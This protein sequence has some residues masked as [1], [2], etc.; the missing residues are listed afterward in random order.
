MQSLRNTLRLATEALDGVGVDCALIG[1]LAMAG[2]GVHRATMDVDLLIDGGQREVARSALQAAGF[3]LQAETPEVLHFTGAGALDLLLANR[4][5]TQDML[6][7][8]RVLEPVQVRCVGAEDI[9]GL[10]IQAYVNNPKRML[11]DKADI[12]ALIEKHSDLDWARVKRYADLFDQWT[13]IEK[14]RSGY[15]I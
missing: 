2:L 11:Q 14:I 4:E 12:A 10:K 6:R 3:E 13:A 5:P 8:A 9:I 15:D 1:G 7:R